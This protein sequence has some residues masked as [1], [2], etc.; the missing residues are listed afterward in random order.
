MNKILIIGANSAI[1]QAVAQRY[2]DQGADLY[3]MAR[4]VSNLQLLATDL[5]VRGASSV[6][7]D[8]FKAEE[9]DTLIG[10]VDQAFEELKEIDIVLVAY[11]SLPDQR[12]CEADARLTAQAFQVNAGSVLVLLTHLANYFEAQGTGTLAVIG[13][14][15]GDRGRQ[16]NYV[17]GA[18]K[19]ALAIF[20][21][22]LR[23]RLHPKGVHVLTIKPGF[24]DTPMTAE[25]PKGALWSSPGD[26]AAAI[27]KAINGKRDVVY[28]PGWWR[29]IMLAIRSTPEFVFKRLK[30]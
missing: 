28:V 17:Y 3:L 8:E 20:L 10:K 9:L 14:V 30:L 2:A 29:W 15:A 26:V 21:Q 23:N 5:R 25:F 19:G 13:S 16:S 22:G 24:V 18:A 11:G 7:Y 4:N 27:V 12:A 1:A 6:H